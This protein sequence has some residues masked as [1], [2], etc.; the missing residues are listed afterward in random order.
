MPLRSRR[1]FESLVAD[2]IDELPGWVQEAMDNVAVVVEDRPPAEDTA[3]LGL[4]EGIAQ[5]ERESYAGV[6]PDR[7]TLYRATIESEAGDDDEELR[8]VIAETVV[9]EVAHHF[10]ISDER[11][12]A[13]GWD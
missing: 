6:L 5:T 9:H 11:L 7:I 8:A 1:R 2:A 12:E 10:G 13:L 4:Y 3:L